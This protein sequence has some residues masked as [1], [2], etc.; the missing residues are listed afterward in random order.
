MILKT[1]LI[2]SIICTIISFFL[3]RRWIL[4]GEWDNEKDRMDKK[5]ELK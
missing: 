2:I 3:F 5:D 1:I 4:K